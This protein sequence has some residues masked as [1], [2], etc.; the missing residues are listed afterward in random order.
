MNFVYRADFT[1]DQDGGFLVTFADVAEAI[2]HGETHE[3]ALSNAV[4][5]LGLALRGYLA[6]GRPLPT[7]AVASGTPVA[8]DAEDAIKLAL[9]DAFRASGISK[10]ELAR[11]LGKNEAEARRL[12]DPDHPSKT[13]A[14][15]SA[16]RTL[17]KSISIT[18]LEAA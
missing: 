9:I 8:V 13:G 1:P 12:L 16:L 5:A 18:V 2:T 11:R 4:E 14:M 15:Q 7:P 10:T 17:G 3:A 6:D